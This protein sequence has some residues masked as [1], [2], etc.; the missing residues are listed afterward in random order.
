MIKFFE[1]IDKKILDYIND[2]FKSK[3]LDKIMPFITVFG[4]MG[5]IWVVLAILL[6]T[7]EKYRE[8]GIMIMITLFFTTFI[9]EIIIKNIFKRKRPFNNLTEQSLLIKKPLT[10]S[11]PSGHTASSFAVAGVFM[12]Y[13]SKLSLY[14]TILASLITFS[15]LYL[16]VH[17]PSDVFFGGILGVTCSFLIRCILL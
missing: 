6:M 16:N 5:F 9:G 4:D 11:F 10:Y 7:K 8:M 17:Y 13:D 2:H 15:R 12:S 14:I 3:F 1:K